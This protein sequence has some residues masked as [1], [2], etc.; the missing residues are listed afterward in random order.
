MRELKSIEERILERALYL[1][2]VNK[3]CDISIRA[4][5]KEANVNVS[6][7]N[8][9][10]RSKEEML[11]MVKEFYLANT[12]TVAAILE[13][14]EL[15]PEEKLI[16]AANEIMEYSLQFPGNMVILRESLKWA[17]EDA[18]SRKVVEMSLGVG[19]RLSHLLSMLIPGDK[20]CHAYKY[21]MFM[22]A[23]N[24]P[25]EDESSILFKNDMLTQK[26]ERLAYLKL[27][28]KALKSA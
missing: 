6:A 3:T 14:E 26:E 11:G 19:E 17:E 5:A 25:T 18:T 9:Y 22:S 1:M 23:I 28:L 20:A 16:L 12:S 8:Y 27:L 13:Q 2:G 24:Y 10:F 7:I 21:M 4:I 15:D